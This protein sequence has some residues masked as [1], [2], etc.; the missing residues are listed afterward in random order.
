MPYLS[1]SCARRATAHNYSLLNRQGLPNYNRYGRGQAPNGQTRRR[2][3]LLRVP[4][5]CPARLSMGPCPATGAV[6]P[7]QAINLARPAGSARV[8][9]L[10]AYM[11]TWQALAGPH[12]QTASGEPLPRP[13]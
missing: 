10:G 12:G 8:S 11:E 5:E 4:R 3:S 6:Y 2:W 9:A 1:N 13:S 7:V